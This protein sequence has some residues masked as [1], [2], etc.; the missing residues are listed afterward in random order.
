[1]KKYL[2]LFLVF[3]TSTTIFSQVGIGTTSPN[4]SSILDIESSDS[5]VLFPRLTTVQRNAISSPATGLLIYNSSNNSFQYNFGTPAIP[6]WISLSSNQSQAGTH[7]VGTTATGWNYYTVTFSNAF[8]N[9]PSILLTFR[10]GTGINNSGSNSVSHFKVAN[11]SITG[12]TIG[13]YD[14]G[15]TSDV[16]ID[17]IAIPR[18]Q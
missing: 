8:T 5:G 16:F 2:I 7:N 17:W 1:M 15:A 12:F 18:T 13:I 14:I 3:S 11:A 4:G 6:N 10:E 9:I